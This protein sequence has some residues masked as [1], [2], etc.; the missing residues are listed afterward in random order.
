MKNPTPTALSIAGTDPSGGAGVFADIKT[1]MAHGVYG[2]GV[3]AA[4]TAQNTQGVSAIY[5]PP[6]A[7][8][9]QQIDT[10]L[11]DVAVHGI[12]IG[13]LGEAATVLCVAERLIYWRDELAKPA[14]PAPLGTIVLD[15][16]ML[17]KNGAALLSKAAVST[18]REALLPQVTI[19]TPNLPEAEALLQCGR[20]ES[21]REMRRA[22]EKLRMLLHLNRDCWV[23]LKG[24][25]LPEYA[26]EGCV[27]YLHNG[28]VMIAL[29]GA[30]VQTRNTHGT[31]CALSAAL[32]ALL[33]RGLAVEDAAQ[34]AHAWLG[35]AIAAADNLNIGQKLN[36]EPVGAGPV[37]HGVGLKTI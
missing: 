10:L 17:S 22:A 34:Q 8:V 12:K 37:N 28:D 27:D 4:M 26:A 23:Y 15:P 7:F 2:C 9:G 1:F 20:I 31:G 5:A 19:L 25:H 33:A 13:M 32:A 3:V 29:R 6:A 21:E 36:G 18:L 16:V 30:R 35:R 11:V 24:G 14:S